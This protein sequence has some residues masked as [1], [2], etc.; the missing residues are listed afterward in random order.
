[1]RVIDLVS[2][3]INSK[4]GWAVAEQFEDTFTEEESFEEQNGYALSL[5]AQDCTQLLKSGLLEEDAAEELKAY[6]E[7]LREYL[8]NN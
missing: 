2:P 4:R 3:Y 7:R 1:M 6:A 8:K 5:V